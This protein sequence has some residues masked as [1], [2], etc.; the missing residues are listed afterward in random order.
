[1]T[2]DGGGARPGVKALASVFLALTL[3]L[4]IFRFLDADELEHVH[5]TWHVLN[6]AVPYVD[7]FQHHHPLLW[8]VLAP[9]LAVAGES[10]ATLVLFRLVFFLLTLA[11]AWATY[12]FARECRASREAAWLSVCLLLS[13]TTFV[14]VA[15]EIRPDVP[16]TLF[17]VLS[18]LYFTRM[19]RSET[20]P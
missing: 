15:I 16:Q 6:G 10:A 2:E 8:Y 13:M 4:S 11:I 14:Y 19:L 18:A 9:A 3:A 7:F 20:P 17:G 1:M 12:R 5:S